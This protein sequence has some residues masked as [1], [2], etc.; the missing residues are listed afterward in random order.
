MAPDVALPDIGGR[1]VHLSD[2]WRV[3]PLVLVFYRGWASPC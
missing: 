1:R 2:L 3:G